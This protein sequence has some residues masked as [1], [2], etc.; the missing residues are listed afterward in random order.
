MKGSR[1]AVGKE[2]DLQRTGIYGS[3]ASSKDDSLKQR[4]SPA[5]V[6]TLSSF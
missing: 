1:G 4:L 6:F 5:G 2:N 3:I